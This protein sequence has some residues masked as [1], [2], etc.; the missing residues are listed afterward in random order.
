MID[1]N[2]T[3][4]NVRYADGREGTVSIRDLAPCPEGSLAKELDISDAKLPEKMEMIDCPDNA[5]LQIPPNS[6]ISSKSSDVTEICNEEE[7]ES[8]KGLSNDTP[9]P[10][11]TNNTRNSTSALWHNYFSLGWKNVV[12]RKCN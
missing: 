5:E 8:F 6:Q 3:Y 12:N 2:P 4:A 11:H 9:T 1:A 10:F 7:T